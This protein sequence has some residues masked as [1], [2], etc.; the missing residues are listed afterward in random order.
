MLAVLPAELEVGWFADFVEWAGFTW[1]HV[2][3]YGV[4]GLAVGLVGDW[5]I[6]RGRG[7]VLCYGLCLTALAVLGLYFICGAVIYNRA[8][9][10]GVQID[11]PQWLW[12]VGS[13]CWE[14]G[15][16]ALHRHVVSR[17]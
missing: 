12:M 10:V 8:P 2:L 17:E 14:G 5:L 6:A 7:R 9:D 13:L 3:L 16:L 4:I 11:P 1:L 15:A